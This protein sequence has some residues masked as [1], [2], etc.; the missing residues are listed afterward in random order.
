MGTAYDMVDY[1]ST[2]RI[3]GEKKYELCFETFFRKG[4]IVRSGIYQGS[5]MGNYLRYT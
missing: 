3:Y 1:Y 5:I 4:N 2:Y